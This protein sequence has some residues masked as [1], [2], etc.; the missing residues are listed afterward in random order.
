MWYFSI[1]QSLKNP[2]WF[3]IKARLAIFE[4]GFEGILTGK[5]MQLV[6]TDR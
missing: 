2:N 1:L 5:S 4:I 3:Y 6:H